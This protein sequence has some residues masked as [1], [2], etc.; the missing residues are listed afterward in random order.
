MARPDF[1]PNDLYRGVTIPVD[2]FGEHIFGADLTPGGPPKHDAQGRRIVADGN[3]Y[4]V[5]MTDNRDMAETSYASPRHGTP[6]PDS[7]QFHWRGSPQ[8]VLEAPTVGVLYQIDP[9]WLWDLRAPFITS[10]LNGVYNNGFS[11]DEWI[12]DSVPARHHRVVALRLGPDTLHKGELLPIGA[13]PRETVASARAIVAERIARL[14]AAAKVI[15]D[16]PGNKRHMYGTVEREL[17]QA[18]G[19]GWRQGHFTTADK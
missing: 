11:G 8:S 2:S 18:F 19:K 1:P 17:D 7:P 3:E 12:A 14:G 9:N 16:M 4:G 13:N 15:R 6:I 10:S 5:Y